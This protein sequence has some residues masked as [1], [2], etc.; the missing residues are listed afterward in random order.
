MWIAATVHPT[1]RQ[2]TTTHCTET[3]FICS[4]RK[5]NLQIISSGFLLQLGNYVSDYYNL[6]GILDSDWLVVTFQGLLF[7]DN[8]L[9]KLEVLKVRR[10]SFAY[11]S[12]V[13]LYEDS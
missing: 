9:L 10:L 4:T 11:L 2:M 1:D 3:L 7:L 8:I 6:S 12:F 13:F 5:F